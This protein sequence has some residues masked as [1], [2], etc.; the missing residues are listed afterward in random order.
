M[1]RRCDALEM[2][3]ATMLSIPRTGVR[4][5]SCYE[6]PEHLIKETMIPCLVDFTRNAGTIIKT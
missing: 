6:H 1:Q 4:V 2:R 5:T 3:V